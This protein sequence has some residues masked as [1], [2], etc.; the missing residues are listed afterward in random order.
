M[1][2]LVDH[3]HLV[4]V[5][6][7]LLALLGAHYLVDSILQRFEALA[8][9]RDLSSERRTLSFDNVAFD[10]VVDFDVFQSR[11]TFSEIHVLVFDVLI[12]WLG[13]RVG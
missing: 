2:F 13:F 8:E 1:Q 12:S 6:Q 9:I 3:P 4:G 11:E 7:R 5:G 10:S